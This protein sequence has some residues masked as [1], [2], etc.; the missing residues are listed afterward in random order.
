VQIEQRAVQLLVQIEQRAVQ[1]VQMSALQLVR[2]SSL[3]Q[4]LEPVEF[5]LLVNQLRAL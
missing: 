5:H 4:I 3:A 1:L 2:N